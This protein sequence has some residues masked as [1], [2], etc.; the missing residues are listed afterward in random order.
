M[1]MDA[2][3]E[4]IRVLGRCDDALHAAIVIPA[5]FQQ[6]HSP[7]AQFIPRCLV[8]CDTGMVM[9]TPAPQMWIDRDVDVGPFQKLMHHLE[10]LNGVDDIKYQSYLFFGFSGG[11]QAEQFFDRLLK[12][13]CDVVGVNCVEQNVCTAICRRTMV[14]RKFK[15]G[16][17][18]IDCVYTVK[19]T[20]G[21]VKDK[22]NTVVFSLIEAWLKGGKNAKTNFTINQAAPLLTVEDLKEEWA[23]LTK[24]EMEGIIL[25]AEEKVK[26]KRPH[27]ARESFISTMGRKVL[28]HMTSSS[29]TPACVKYINHDDYIPLERFVGLSGI[30]CRTF[31]VISDA[32]VE[33]P[34]LEWVANSSG[35]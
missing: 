22:A 25:L 3:P 32:L 17:I 13:G 1:S 28:A 10:L 7:D 9:T 20:R 24:D 27:T 2:E 23:G 21:H 8:R 6:A 4:Q 18:G 14:K 12:N 35:L 30:I 31:D 15:L 5:L 34:V 16:S 33:F 29:S 11:E 19:H 26:C